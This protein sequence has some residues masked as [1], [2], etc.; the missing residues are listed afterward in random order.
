MNTLQHLRLLALLALVG[1]SPLCALAQEA[2]GSTADPKYAESRNSDACKAEEKR[3]K[4]QRK[5]SLKSLDKG[6][7]KV[8][9][10]MRF[11]IPRMYLQYFCYDPLDYF[12]IVLKGDTYLDKA[13]EKTDTASYFL[14]Y[15]KGVVKME[16]QQYA[17]ALPYFERAMDQLGEGADQRYHF[18]YARALHLNGDY[19]TAL[20]HYTKALSKISGENYFS[21]ALKDYIQQCNNALLLSDPD[22]EVDIKNLGTKV[23]SFDMEYAPVVTPDDSVLY[24]TVRGRGPKC[25]LPKRKANKLEKLRVKKASSLYLENIYRT[26]RTSEGAEGWDCPQMLPKPINKKRYD[27]ASSFVT[28]ND[29]TLYIYQR[30]MFRLKKEQALGNLFMITKNENAEDV[31]KKSAWG[32]LVEIEG[33]NS[34]AHEPHIAISADRSFAIFA[35]DRPGGYGGYDLYI[36]YST[37]D[38]QFGQPQNLGE[39]INTAEDERAPFIHKNGK[40]V[41]FSSTGHSSIGGHDIFKTRLYAGEW[42]EPQNLGAPMNSA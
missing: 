36:A 11:I 38:G 6:K 26:E 27:N 22:S 19:E 16:S 32:E 13:M 5:E 24:Y 2:E 4:E 21:Q 28:T 42:K 31:S 7:G 25:Q 1:L 9:K 23:N 30:K 3:I 34:D 8:K 39:T 20:E 33:V 14:L 37:G 10:A 18:Y 41:Y 15:L 17:D 12:E 40:T 29:D 35:S